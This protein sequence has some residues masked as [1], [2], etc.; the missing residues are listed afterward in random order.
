MKP[1]MQETL[2]LPRINYRAYNGNP[3]RHVFGTGSRLP[4]N[5]MDQLVK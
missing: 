2:E 4:R 3:Y 5:F 1:L